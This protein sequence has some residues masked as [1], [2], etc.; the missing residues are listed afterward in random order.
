MTNI[1]RATASQWIKKERGLGAAGTSTEEA[2]VP[3]ADSSFWFSMWEQPVKKEVK[4]KGNTRNK[5]GFEMT[6]R[7]G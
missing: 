1:Q 6:W 3:V 2:R 5:R 7:L 4:P